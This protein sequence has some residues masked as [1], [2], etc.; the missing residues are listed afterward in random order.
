MTLLARIL[1]G[2]SATLAGRQAVFNVIMNRAK[3]NYGGFGS[4][5]IAQATAPR[6]FSCYPNALGPDDP[7]AEELV[8]AAIA[9]TLGNIVPNSLN[10]ANPSIM[11]RA[12]TAGS[13]VWTALA[14]GE[15]VTIGGNTFWAN[16]KG[17]SPGYDPSKIYNPEKTMPIDTP[18]AAPAPQ[19]A[20]AATSAMPNAVSQTIEKVAQGIDT[21]S[22]FEPEVAAV[23]GFVPG[24]SQIMAIV[25]PFA[26]VIL[27]FAS[28]ALHD[29]AEANGGDLPA[30]IIELLQHVTKG[31]PTS[32]TLS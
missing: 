1:T 3:I 20:S 7:V 31:Q 14:S 13:W 5:W 25:Q 29:I 24:A 9:G 12:K 16:D 26:P 11:D 6:Q 22:K 23:A 30:A 28:R 27:A 15:G 21:F 8:Q 2:E 32:K 4:T 10:Y 17:G 19:P 18:P